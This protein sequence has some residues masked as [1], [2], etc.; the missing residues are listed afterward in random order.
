M[1]RLP[2]FILQDHNFKKKVQWRLFF[3]TVTFL[4]SCISYSSCF[5][6][7]KL[8]L[9]LCYPYRITETQNIK[10]F[11]II[12]HRKLEN[13]LLSII[14]LSGTGMHLFHQIVSVYISKSVLEFL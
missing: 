12:F 13:S 8:P 4:K 9:G 2:L 14:C 7:D 5:Y 1:K 10:C 6:I 3:I 11:L